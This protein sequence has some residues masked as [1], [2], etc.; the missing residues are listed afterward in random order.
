MIRK[1]IA[2]GINGINFCTLNLEKS[3]Q[4][5]LEGLQWTIHYDDRHWNKL[6]NVGGTP[7]LSG[8]ERSHPVCP[9]WKTTNPCRQKR[10]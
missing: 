2:N 5:I 9:R 6:I 10:T 1:L 3:V 4:L 7:V 8:L